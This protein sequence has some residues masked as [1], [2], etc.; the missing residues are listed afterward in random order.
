MFE[1]A[2]IDG[3]NVVYPTLFPT[4]P[5]VQTT[6]P[7]Y[8]TELEGMEAYEEAVKRDEVFIFN[9]EEEANKFAEGSWKDYRNVDAEGTSFF[10]ERGYDYLTIKDQFDE[11]ERARDA[12]FFIEDK[13][14]RGIG[15]ELKNLTPEEQQKYAYLYNEKGILR[16]DAADILKREQKI[17]DDLVDIYTD[18]DLQE[19]REDFDV[20]ID[21]QFQ[22]LSQRSGCNQLLY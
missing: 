16:Q 8:W 9:T 13:L 7:D 19:V 15:Q 6:N 21:K 1:S 14:D 12:A 18:D 20:Y 10:R 11:Y 22:E 4:N 5:N 17:V 3:K 2:V